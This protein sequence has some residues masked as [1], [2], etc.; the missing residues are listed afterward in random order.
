MW[1]TLICQW[2]SVRLVPNPKFPPIRNITTHQIILIWKRIILV[3]SQITLRPS[4]FN[5]LLNEW[6]LGH[7]RVGRWGVAKGNSANL[8]GWRSGER[9]ALLL[10]VVTHA[11]WWNFPAGQCDGCTNELKNFKCPFFPPHLLLFNVHTNLMGIL[12][13]CSFWFIRSRGRSNNLHFYQV[14]RQYWWPWCMDLT[15]RC[16]VLESF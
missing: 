13:K 3:L 16:K 10:L 8:S 5:K 11:H 7:A 6:L 14:P 12:W 15:L 2:I 4:A 1:H 9:R